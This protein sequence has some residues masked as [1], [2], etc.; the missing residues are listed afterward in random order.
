MTD[1]GT[2]NRE[3]CAPATNLPGQTPAPE[4]TYV[5][6]PSIF[7]ILGQTDPA[8]EPGELEQ[9]RAALEIANGERAKLALRLA[10]ITCERQQVSALLMENREQGQRSHEEVQRL[11][12]ELTQTRKALEL[13]EAQVRS[14]SEMRTAAQG[15]SRQ[16]REERDTLAKSAEAQSGSRKEMEQQVVSLIGVQIEYE[17]LKRLAF[18]MK[19]RIETLQERLRASESPKSQ[20]ERAEIS[21]LSGELKQSRAQEAELLKKLTKVRWANQTAKVKLEEM[22]GQLASGAQ[23]V[24][25][26]E[27][28]ILL[29]KEKSAQAEELSRQLKELA[30]ENERLRGQLARVDAA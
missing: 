24:A 7:D 16:L 17:K 10:D 4:D 21:R 20:E 8:R 26:L 22:N 14:E 12:E 1:F 13:A 11:R 9:I 18:R 3:A 29:E 19:R 23:N 5:A 28:A 15:E 6:W 2:A 25:G 27:E 30:A